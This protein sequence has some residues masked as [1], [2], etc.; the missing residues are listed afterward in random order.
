MLIPAEL[1]HRDPGTVWKALA[2]PTRREILDLLRTRPRTTGDL[3]GEFELSRF[4]V[5]KHLKVLV[6][7]HLVY[8]RRRGR[9]RWNHLNPVPIQE[10]AR[11][12]I[13]PF[14]VAAAER[15]LRLKTVAGADKERGMDDSVS[16]RFRTVTTELEVRIDAT[17]ERVWEALTSE[18]AAWW[19]AGFYVGPSPV[20]FTVEPRVGGR[21]FEDWGGGEG[22]LWATVTSVRAGA[23]LEWVGDLSAAYGGPGRSFTSFVLEPMG[24]GTLLKFRDDTSGELGDGVEKHMP[25]GWRLLVAETLKP[26]VESGVQPERPASVIAAEVARG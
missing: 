11:R 18:V 17:P 3:A 10:I 13:T 23:V 5:M 14:E 8:V 6:D 16:R 9:E 12:W 24:S 4:G 26:Y 15:L 2:D 19:P 25:D 1:T 21:V 20:R 22:A 7:A